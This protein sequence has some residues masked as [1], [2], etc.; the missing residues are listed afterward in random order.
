MKNIRYCWKLQQRK[1]IKTKCEEGRSS[2]TCKG[3]LELRLILSK[4][5][6]IYV[7]L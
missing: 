4:L 6:G 5:S 2:G 1:E 3:I 7:A